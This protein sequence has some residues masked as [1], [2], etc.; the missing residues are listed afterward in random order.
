MAEQEQLQPNV[1]TTVDEAQNLSEFLQTRPFAPVNKS[2]AASSEPG[3]QPNLQIKSTN[4]LPPRTSNFGHSFGNV[5]VFLPTRSVIQAKLTIGQPGDKYEQEADRVAADVLQRINQP[6]AMS[7]NQRE[8]IQRMEVPEE[9]ELQMK[10]LVNSIQRMEVP[11][12]EELQM[13]PLANSIQRVEV[14]EE[15]ELQMKPFLQRQEAIDGGQ[16]STDLESSIN[17]A[18][19]GGQ[20]LDAGLQQSMGQAMGADFSGVRV[21]TDTQADQLNKSIQAKAF[22]TGQDVFFRQGTYDPGS[23][24]G[25]ELIAHELTHVVQQN[26]GAV[27][28]SPQPEDTLRQHQ[29]I[30]TGAKAVTSIQRKAYI[31]DNCDL[32]ANLEKPKNKA[33]HEDG[34]IRRFNNQQEFETFA[35]GSAVEGVGQLADKTWVRLPKSMLVLG[36]N[37]GN[38]KAPEII[39]ATNIKKFRYEGFTHHSATRLEKSE[40]LQGVVQESNKKSLEKKGLVAGADEPTHEAE[41][42]L[43]KYARAV[44]DVIELVKKQE[45]GEKISETSVVAGSDLGEEYSLVKALLSSLLHALIYSKSYSGKFFSHP[46]KQFY[47][48]NQAAVDEAIETLKASEQGKKVPDFSKLKITNTLDSLTTAYETAAKSKVGLTTQK[49]IDNF[50]AQ[51]NTV[52]EPKVTLTNRAKEDDYLRDASMLETIKKAKSSGDRLFVI[53]DAHRYKLQPLIEGLGLEVMPDTDFVAQQKDLDTYAKSNGKDYGD[54]DPKSIGKWI[55]S[56]QEKWTPDELIKLGWGRESESEEEWEKRKGNNNKGGTAVLT[57]HN[58]TTTRYEVVINGKIIDKK[59]K[60]FQYKRGD[61]YT[62]TAIS[63]AEPKAKIVIYQSQ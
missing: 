61:K 11:E 44:A 2:H 60:N 36:E 47:N 17:N 50:K 40:E 55:R 62:I 37:H 39:K 32:P 18:R 13:K 3:T 43:P 14:P 26:S 25:Q 16:A 31:G 23:R 24:G 59:T 28:R 34:D 56:I 33:L 46:L 1:L 51:L 15:E 4:N 30:M 12:E 8:T 41:H 20:A 38:P 10:P 45:K 19:G 9:E 6:Q 5:M 48:E 63:K 21:H 35:A 58:D 54:G 29:E 49:K 53:G 57:D 7:S 22:T 42:A 27:Q 52:K